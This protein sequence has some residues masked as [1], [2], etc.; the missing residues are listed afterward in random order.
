MGIRSTEIKKGVNLHY[1]HTD[2]FKT[3]TVGIYFH[4]PLLKSEATLNALLPNVLRRGCPLFPETAALSKR[5]DEL[6]GARLN[7]GV[8]KKGDS[9]I[10]YFNFEFV[11]ERYIGKTENTLESIL[12]LMQSIVLGQTGFSSDYVNQEKENLKQQILSVIND[13]RAYAVT[14][15]TEIMC[16]GEPYGINELGFIED[17]DGIN[18]NSLY[19]HYKS[20]VLSSPVDIFLC[21]DVDIFW[22]EQRISDIFNGIDPK[23]PQYPETTIVKSVG[24]VK[25]VTETEQISQGKLSLGFRTG[26]QPGDGKYPALLVYNAV[27]GGGPSSKLFN[28]VREK[29]SLA[30]YASSKTDMFKG[31]MTINSGIEVAN[32]QKAYDEIMLQLEAVKKGE[33]TDEEMSAAILAMV[34][35][36]KSMADSAA[37]MEDYWLGRLIAGV[38]I[39]LGELSDAVANVTKEQVI[40]IAQDVTLDTVYFLKG[41]QVL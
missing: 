29:L 36:I 11:N 2:K 20:M 18:E 9:Q 6:Y 7:S 13:K 35:G 23:S 4:R 25:N 10:I 21:G 15:C 3:N 19:K 27:L 32:Y 1:I 30:Y 31:I 40:G 28:N 14:R 12:S 39:P 26:V 16:E 37:V 8:R 24:N 41:E 22:V 17:I 33:I 5:L 38:P 34:N